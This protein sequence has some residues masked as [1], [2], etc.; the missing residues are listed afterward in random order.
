MKVLEEGKWKMVW[1]VEVPCSQ[2]ECG[3]KLLVEE[4]DVAP[5]D[6]SDPAKYSCVCPVCGSEIS[7]LASSIPLRVKK[8]ADK[9]KKWSSSDW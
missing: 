5:V 9:K 2:K 7:L 8:V 1:S 4:A 3:A 6:Y